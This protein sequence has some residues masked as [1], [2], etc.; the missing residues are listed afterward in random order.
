VILFRTCHAAPQRLHSWSWQSIPQTQ[1]D[2]LATPL[3]AFLS[4]AT[5]HLT[6]T[7]LLCLR[8]SAW[9]PRVLLWFLISKRPVSLSSTSFG[10]LRYLLPSHSIDDLLKYSQVV[11]VK[12]AR[13]V[14]KFRDFDHHLISHHLL[15]ATT[16]SNFPDSF[17]L[18]RLSYH[19]SRDP[20]FFTSLYFQSKRLLHTR[21]LLTLAHHQSST[22]ST[23]V[24]TF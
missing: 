4:F 17:A 3:P 6:P 12:S 20:H 9:A 1:L 21:H 24:P 10:H 7:S 13:Q 14:R 15:A 2:S 16:T 18:V 19:Q 11:A 5:S 8:L 22:A 23:L